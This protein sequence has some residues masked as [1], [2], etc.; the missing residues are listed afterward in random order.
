VVARSQLAALARQ[1]GQA[2]RAKAWL[3]EVQQADATAGPARTA[4]TRALAGQAALTLAEPLFEG[5][6]QVLLVEP[7]Q[8]QLKLKKAR[9]D[10]VL[11]A[12]TAAA[13]LG[14]AEVSTAA[15]ERTAAV[16]QDFGRALMASARPKK[17]NKAELEQYNVMLEEQ[18]FPFEEKAI[19]LHESN[20]RR[21]AGGLYDTHVQRSF[22]ALAELKPVRWGKVERGDASLPNDIA[23]LEA[24]LK[25]NG[26]QPRLLN[27]LGI[28]HRMAGRFDAAR[29]NYEAAIALDANAV[30]P[31]LNLA[32]LHD[33][34]LGDAAVAQSHYQRCV[35]LAPGDLPM[36]GKWVAELKARKPV[37][38]PRSPDAPAVAAATTT[39]LSPRKDTP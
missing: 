6:R 25:A 32:I 10:E 15:T 9:M 38:A 13:E 21:A 14:V 18:A 31:E 37:S 34:Y 2:V 20:A 4:R 22:A 8:K 7:L 30:A 26:P 3:K 28:A 17:L 1:D 39:P 23:A 12:Y 11:Q 29:Q 35:E 16:Y 36:L 24:A 5:Y 33:L 27:Q 19:E